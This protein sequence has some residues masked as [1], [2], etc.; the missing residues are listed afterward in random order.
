MKKAG[1][2]F[3]TID[4]KLKPQWRS[5]SPGWHE[6]ER[7]SRLVYGPSHRSRQDRGPVPA[8]LGRAVFVLESAGAWLRRDPGVVVIPVIPES[9]VRRVWAT[10]LQAGSRSAATEAM[11]EMLVEAGLRRA[12]AAVAA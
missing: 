12:P 8:L 1:P 9:P 7:G 2:R 5:S 11:L 3:P 10:T 6:D 4:M